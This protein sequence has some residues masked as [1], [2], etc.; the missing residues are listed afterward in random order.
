MDA[1]EGYR[2]AIEYVK[3]Q[4]ANPQVNQGVYCGIKAIDDI[5]NGFT[6]GTY[7]VISGM[8]KG[9]KTTMMFNMANNMAKAGKH[10]VYVSIEKK[11]KLLW[12]RL[13]C[14]NSLCD[15][16]RVKRGGKGEHGITDYWFEKLME[17]EKELQEMKQ[18]FNCLQ[19]LPE[20]K[21]PA[22]LAK[23]ER[24]RMARPID[25]LFVDYLGAIGWDVTYQGRVD[26]NIATVH[27]QLMAYGKRHNLVLITASQLKNE[28]TKEVRKKAKKAMSEGDIQSVSVNTEDY[29]YTQTIA[30]DADNAISLILPEEFPPT[31][32]LVHVTKARDDQAHKTVGLLFDGAI[33]R[34]YDPNM[35]PS[36]YTAIEEMVYDAGVT[37]EQLTSDENLF[38]ELDGEV[39]EASPE[40]EA[41]VE[42]PVVEEEKVVESDDNDMSFL[43]S[44]L[45]PDR[46]GV[47]TA[48][49]SDEED[50]FDE[51]LGL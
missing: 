16:N 10:V 33:G 48:E 38:S 1:A 14:L 32:I 24:E 41:P 34:I 7:T 45:N 19:F 42:A 5:F 49:V 36:E 40:K 25:V 13:L 2:Q 39:V 20:T 47:P 31:N 18:N 46:P 11:A 21:L 50:M 43:E 28:S 3:E 51:G 23:V 15:Y 17:T 26:M 29:G 37:Q 9:G 35:A 6:P 12:R 27:K 30:A 4:R 22:I 44:S 8:V